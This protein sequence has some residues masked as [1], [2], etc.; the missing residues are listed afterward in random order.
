MEGNLFVVN[1]F[2]IDRLDENIHRVSCGIQ[3]DGGESNQIWFEVSG[4]ASGRSVKVADAFF[5]PCLLFAMKKGADI[6]FDVP[7]SED[8]AHQSTDLVFVFGTQLGLNPRQ[9]VEFTETV[10]LER[11]VTGGITGFSGGVDSW[12]SL[13]KNLIDCDLPTKRITHLL[14]NDVGANA[15]ESK[16]DQVLQLARDVASDLGLNVVSVRSNMVDFLPIG[17]QQTHTA[18]NVSVGHLLTSIADTFYYSSGLTYSHAGVFATDDMAHA[19]T[20]I[21]P[22]LSTATMALRSTG[23]AVTRAEKTREICEIPRIGERLDVCF[24]HWSGRAK[25]NCGVCEK[26]CRTLLTLE[27]FGLLQEFEASFDLD[28]YK[29]RRSRFLHKICVSKK[30]DEIEVFGLAESAGLIGPR[31]YHHALGLGMKSVRF[32]KSSFNRPPH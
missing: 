18:R 11:R 1:K 3:G 10:G 5:A 23:S 7:I 28:A 31:L 24:N 16:K 25:I 8:I 15:T 29:K 17:F 22:L 13:K 26:C 9:R 30:P 27:V 21:L 6:R 20:I 19:D 32:L 2:K 14:V 4:I 12:Y